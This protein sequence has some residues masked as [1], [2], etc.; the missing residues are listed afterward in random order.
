MN[1]AVQGHEAPAAAAAPLSPGVGLLVLLGLIVVIGAFLWIT[2]LMSITE[3]WVA[4]LFLLYWAGI[5]HSSM[6]MLPST[7]C[8]AVCGLLLAYALQQLP[9]LMGN[10]GLGVFLG[11]ILAAVFCQ[12]VG[13]LPLLINMSCM[14]FLT[15]GTIPLIQAGFKLPGLLMALAAGI[16]YFGGIIWLGTAWQARRAKP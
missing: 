9:L 8:G 3:V 7:I 14:L 13:W 11:L 6:A 16:V 1:D 2:H 5:N 4:F 12:I 10:A 15:V